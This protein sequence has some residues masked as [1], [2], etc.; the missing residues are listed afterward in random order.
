MGIASDTRIIL[1]I[2]RYGWLMVLVPAILTA[3]VL[4]ILVWN[5]VIGG[6]SR[7]VATSV[8][9]FIQEAYSGA[10]SLRA[11]DGA[12]ARLGRMVEQQVEVGNLVSVALY[13]ANGAQVYASTGQVDSPAGDQEPAI[14]AAILAGRVT[15]VHTGDHYIAGG[16]RTPTIR[17]T[18]PVRLTPDGP[19][20][21][22]TVSYRPYATVRA[23]AVRAVLAAVAVVLLGAAITYALLMLL[24]TNAARAIREG[25]A[26]SR[27]LN[28]RLHESMRDQ[29]EQ[30]VGTVQALMAAVNAK[31]SYT[32]AHSLNVSA[33]ACAVAEHAGWHDDAAIVEQAG[34]VHDIG[35]IGIDEA[36][37]L[38]PGR[39]S[40]TEFDVIRSHSSAGAEIVESIPSLR[41]V[42]PAIRHHHERWDGD[43]Y[44]AGLRGDAIP[45]TARLLAVVD[46]FDAM[47]TDRPYRSAMSVQDA[48]DEL[49][50]GRGTQFDPQM[51]DA[52]MKAHA[53][54]AVS[55]PTSAV[56]HR[57]RGFAARD[58]A[59]S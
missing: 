29:E 19:I 8:G 28:Q 38:K 18:S 10:T 3:V 45:R 20:V 12:A 40:S 6:F 52:F 21:G 14:R 13:D 25:E 2:R 54:G 49:G 48:L 4:A 59:A 32:A 15:G 56:V 55:V 1:T 39:L 30:S 36:T 42:I 35:K 50:V 41:P 24:V 57:H 7:M 47:T 51:V 11:D 31:D 26:Q 16:A 44:P 22:A 58:S 9:G 43:G 23:G 27:S 5:L 17:I 34:L 37:L 33:Y 53:A 46:A